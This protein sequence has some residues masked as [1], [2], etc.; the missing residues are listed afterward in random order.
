MV[1]PCL[2]KTGSTSGAENASISTAGN[3]E[4]EHRHEV[5]GPADVGIRE[6]ERPDVVGRHVERDCQAP[7]AGEQRPIRV[8]HALGIAGAAGRVIDPSDRQLGPGPASGSGGSVAGSPSG[9]PSSTTTIAG[10]LS[11]SAVTR[12]AKSRKSKPRNS[13]GTKKKRAPVWRSAKPT[14]RSRYRWMIGFCTAPRRDSAADSTIV[15]IRVGSCHDTGVPSTD[16]KLVQPGR[17]ALGRVAK[18]PERER[19]VL[20]VDE[21]RCRRRRIG[22][23]IDQ[24][25]QRARARDDVPR[26]H[27]PPVLGLLHAADGPRSSHDPAP[28][29]ECPG[30]ALATRGSTAPVP[31]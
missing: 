25:P 27:R 16:A 30:H 23:A 13:P 5:V 20:L 8:A 29:S 10:G 9:R 4:A 6:G 14:S 17:D 11:S 24:L 1:T 12:A 18:L 3:P 28:D 15:S 21:H 7:P 26:G 19:A 22:S 31:V 2:R